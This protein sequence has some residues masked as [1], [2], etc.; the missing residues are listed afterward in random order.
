MVCGIMFLK[1]GFSGSEKPENKGKNFFEKFL[2][3]E[4]QAGRGF[5]GSFPKRLYKK[6]DKKLLTGEKYIDMIVA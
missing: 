3:S 2:I 4:T 6:S 5:A 1:I